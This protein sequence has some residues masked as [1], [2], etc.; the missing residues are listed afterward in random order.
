MARKPRIEY[1]GAIYYVYAE[2]DRNFV[3]SAESAES[4]LELTAELCR[5]FDIRIFAYSFLP[6]EYHLVFQ[7]RRA[8]LSQAMQWFGGNLTR[9]SNRLQKSSGRLFSKRYKSIILKNES[10]LPAAIGRVHAGPVKAGIVKKPEDCL[11][12]SYGFY[13]GQS[14]PPDWFSFAS[15]VRRGPA[16]EDY[17]ADILKQE[18]EILG[19]IE[20]GFN[21]GADN[22]A[23]RLFFGSAPFGHKEKEREFNILDE[24]KI[25]AGWFGRPVEE[26]LAVSK[27]PVPARFDRDL[28]IY[29]LYECG[30][31]TNHEI[32]GVFGVSN[33]SVSHLAR[34]YKKRLIVEKELAARLKKLENAIAAGLE[35]RH[36]A[37]EEVVVNP[38][39]QAIE[40]HIELA[41]KWLGGGENEEIS[42]QAEKSRAMRRKLVQATLV[43][44]DEYG[45]HG[46]TIS[47]IIDRAG[48]SRG[49]WRHHF[50][51][52]K[53]L[54]AEAAKFMYAGSIQRVI[55]FI[56]TLEPDN[57]PLA[58]LFDFTREHFHQGWHRNVWL[59]F[60]V[61]SRTDEEL[62]S[63]V[64]PLIEEFFKAVDNL[65][66][67]LVEALNPELAGSSLLVNLTLYVSR[68][69]AIQSITHDDPEHFKELS[70]L[71]PKL[72]DE[73][74]RLKPSDALK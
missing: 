36:G 23:G 32:A 54:V 1:A 46:T 73:L 47:R 3:E 21:S 11:W 68:G 14:E 16:Y 9:R 45:Y 64:A 31:Y 8:N 15:G 58:A 26:L 17:M 63:L 22:I 13:S 66:D 69:M 56:P 38:V 2:A 18:S 43:C 30:K 71:W 62:R 42:L 37:E 6:G 12:S 39:S 25:A 74:V 4:L 67:S 7:T 33:S 40:R 65:A 49:A 5:R 59:E 10:Y 27:K 61:A 53:A 41:D 44:L 50:P 28:L 20:S 70:D 55:K 29:R 19:V 60:T 48:V 51:N 24:I 52:K 35:S 34:R 72:L 57:N